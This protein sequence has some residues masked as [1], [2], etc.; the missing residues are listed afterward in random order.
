ME[1]GG[2][3]GGGGVVYRPHHEGLFVGHTVDGEL[4]LPG[5]VSGSVG[6]GA[7]KLA[8]VVPRGRRHMQGPVRQEGEGGTTQVQQLP[9]LHRVTHGRGQGLEVTHQPTRKTERGRTFSGRGFP[10]VSTPISRPVSLPCR[11]PS[12]V[13]PRA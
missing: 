10:T 12:R 8:A 7:D 9:A 1:W 11:F 4:H 3:R 6:G 13:S 2:G 5:A